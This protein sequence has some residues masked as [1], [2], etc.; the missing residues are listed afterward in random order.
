MRAIC[1]TNLFSNI[2]WTEGTTI[3]PVVDMFRQ[4][5]RVELC[6]PQSLHTERSKALDIP[7]SSGVVCSGCGAE[8]D[9]HHNR[10]MIDDCPNPLGNDRA[11]ERIAKVCMSIGRFVNDG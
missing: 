4:I 1:Q 10:G 3:V 5:V 8:T 6:R 11:G 9:N 2:L 7:D